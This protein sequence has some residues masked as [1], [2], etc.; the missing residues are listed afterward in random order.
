MLNDLLAQQPGALLVAQND[1]CAVWQ[2]RNETGD[3]TM[4]AY[5]ISRGS[6]SITMIF[7]WNTSIPGLSRRETCWPSTIAG[8]G[9]WNTR[10]RRTPWPI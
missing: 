2:F 9:G 1:E 4:T 10:R 7:I 6:R 3:G 5:S 8:K